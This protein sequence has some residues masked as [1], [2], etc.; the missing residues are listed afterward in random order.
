MAATFQGSHVTAKLDSDQMLAQVLVNRLIL[1]TLNQLSQASVGVYSQATNT[2]GVKSVGV[3]SYTV[4]GAL[5]TKAAT[6]PLWTLTGVAITAVTGT[7]LFVKYLLLLN[8]AGAASVLESNVS[9]VSLASCVYPSMPDGAAIVGVVSITITAVTFTP[10]TTSL[11]AAGIVT[12]V[13]TGTDKALFPL[14]ADASSNQEVLVAS[15]GSGLG[16]AGIGA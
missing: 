2:T 11:S 8:A 15:A 5:L 7:P 14:I 6:D 13:A 3:T 12:T 16:I 10:G 4:D 1:S 9:N